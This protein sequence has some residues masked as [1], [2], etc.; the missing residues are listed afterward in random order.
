MALSRQISV[1][2]PAELIERIKSRGEGSSRFIIEAVRDKLNREDEAEIT[3]SMRCLAYDDEAND[4][5]DF[6]VA[7]DRTIAR[8]D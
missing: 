3:A 5:S 1:R 4:I 2:I 8:G 7:Q 6:A